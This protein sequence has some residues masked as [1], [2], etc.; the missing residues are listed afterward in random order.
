MFELEDFDLDDEV[1]LFYLYIIYSF[2]FIFIEY[3]LN[4]ETFLLYDM[5][6]NFIY[7]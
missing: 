7:V 4:F 6:I 5:N 1:N 3:N 2:L